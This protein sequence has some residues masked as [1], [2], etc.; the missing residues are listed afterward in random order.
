MHD[1][2]R[3]SQHDLLRM[4]GCDSNGPLGDPPFSPPCPPSGR[5][6]AGLHDLKERVD[7]VGLDGITAGRDHLVLWLTHWGETE[8]KTGK[9]LHLF[10]F[11]RGLLN[12]CFSVA[13][14]PN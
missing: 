10:C 7:V 13:R 11:R 6:G 3:H 2:P 4:R 14:S 1:G 12:R 8:R 5:G 9:S